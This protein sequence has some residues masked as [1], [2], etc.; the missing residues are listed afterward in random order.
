MS[1]FPPSLFSLQD[2]VYVPPYSL[3]VLT[4]M[5]LPWIQAFLVP[6]GTM[7]ASKEGKTPTVQPAMWTLRQNDDHYGMKEILM[8]IYRTHRIPEIPLTCSF[9]KL[10]LHLNL[11]HA[12]L[13]I[14]VTIQDLKQYL[15]I[16]VDMMFST[17]LICML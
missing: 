5:S 9:S 13:F 12:Y 7:Q 11:R 16:T 4:W 14:F 1:S 2:I 3:L 17:M 10:L 8:W 15:I 6:E